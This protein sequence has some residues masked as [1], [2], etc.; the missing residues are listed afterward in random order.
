M[1]AMSVGYSILVR[2]IFTSESFLPDIMYP[3]CQRA[4]QEH[5]RLNCIPSRQSDVASFIHLPKIMCRGCMRIE[6]GGIPGVGVFSI[7]RAMQLQAFFGPPSTSLQR[8]IV[9]LIE[10]E[11]VRQLPPHNSLLQKAIHIGLNSQTWI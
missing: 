11:V 7:V 3:H 4:K 2:P 8:I 6:Q 1:L 9:W 5:I 10:A